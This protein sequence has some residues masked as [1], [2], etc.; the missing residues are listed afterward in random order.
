MDFEPWE[1]GIAFEVADGAAV[2]GWSAQQLA[3]LHAAVAT[4]VRDEL[5][6]LEADTPV[7][8]AVV[9]RSIRVHEV[10]SH[11]RSF[12]AAGRLAVRNALA[13]MNPS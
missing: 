5:A 9:L 12:R 4:G 7:A 3:E 11:P 2:G 8:V 13:R 6:G 1:E 10:D